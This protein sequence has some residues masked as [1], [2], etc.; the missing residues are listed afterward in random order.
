MTKKN[1]I[2]DASKGLAHG[3]EKAKS[4]E[5]QERLARALRVNLK[6]RKEQSRSRKRGRQE[7]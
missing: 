6:R 4:A 7:D 3:S 2:D 1:T 5:R